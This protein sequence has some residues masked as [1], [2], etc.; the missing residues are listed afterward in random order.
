MSNFLGRMSF[1]RAVI[2]FCSLGSLV[3]GVLVYLRTQRLEEIKSEL[4]QVEG[5]MREIQTD[6]YTLNDLQRIEGAE[7]FKAQSAPQSYIRSIGTDDK[8]RMGQLDVGE[9]TNT[10]FRGVEDKVYTIKPMSKTQKYTRGQV[11]N[12]LWKLENDSRRVKVTR[13]KL[14]PA[15]K[16]SPGQLGKDEWI[17]EAELTTRSKV[18]TTPAPAATGQG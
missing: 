18:D 10:P 14:T 2:L 4:R 6:A 8:I 5:V 16:L 11:G 13:V 12:F 15:E 17:F 7:K 1:P 9:N 3:L